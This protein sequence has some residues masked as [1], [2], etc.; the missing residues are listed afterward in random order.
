MRNLRFAELRYEEEA[1][2]ALAADR[3]DSGDLGAPSHGFGENHGIGG[4]ES[5]SAVGLH[6]QFVC[7]FGVSCSIR[8]PVKV[9]KSLLENRKGV[10]TC[11]KRRTGTTQIHFAPCILEAGSF[12]PLLRVR[13]CTWQRWILTR[14]ATFFGFCAGLLACSPVCLFVCLFVWLFVCLFVCLFVAL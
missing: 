5:T 8:E 6:W 3:P 1:S 7:G 4:P 12:V 2:E 11:F 10:K 9:A 13:A 14:R